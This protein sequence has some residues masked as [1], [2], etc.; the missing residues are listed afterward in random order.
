MTLEE[1]LLAARPKY[2]GFDTETYGCDPKKQSPVGNARLFCSTFAILKKDLSPFG[3]HRA[4][5]FFVLGVDR[6]A[7]IVRIAREIGTT[8]VA[9]NAGYDRHVL[10]NEAI[11]TAGL[12]YVDTLTLAQYLLPAEQR[13]NLKDLAAKYLRREPVGK[14]KDLFTVKRKEPTERVA[15]H[16]AACNKFVVQNRELHPHPLREQTVLSLRTKSVTL[17][18]REIDQSTRLWVTFQRYAVDDATMSLELFD[19]LRLRGTK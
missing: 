14:F 4:T 2:L 10:A 3:Y 17:D 5:G 7:E 19:Y 12:K 9:H 1:I 11:D 8:L 16:C 13:H 6:T 18:P 15:W